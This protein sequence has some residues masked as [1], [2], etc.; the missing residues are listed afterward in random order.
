MLMTNNDSPSIERHRRKCTVC[1]HADVEAIEEAFVNWTSIPDICTQ[2]GL[3]ERNVY[4]HAT[5][6]N[7]D[8][9]RQANFHKLT[10]KAQ[11][12]AEWALERLI[13]LADGATREEVQLK[14]LDSLLDR[15]GFVRQSKTQSEAKV[16][17]RGM[18]KDERS[19]MYAKV[20]NLVHPNGP[21]AEDESELGES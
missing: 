3:E 16:E 13:Q 18:S 21:P 8:G 9:Q 2:Y 11:E 19:Q 12:K 6:V 17:V 15:A 20:W 1:N 5:A 14:A 7:L 10:E 4:R